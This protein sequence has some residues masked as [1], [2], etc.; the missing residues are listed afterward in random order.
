[1]RSLAQH[2]LILLLCCMV[3][4][5]V[6]SD[7]SRTLRSGRVRGAVGMQAQVGVLQGGVERV[8]SVSLRAPQRLIPVHIQG[9]PP[10]YFIWGGLVFTQVHWLFA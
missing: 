9:R 10:P 3:W 6:F 5:M 4:D 2:I 1:M 7:Q 8:L